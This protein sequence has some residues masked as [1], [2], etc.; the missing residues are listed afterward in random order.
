MKRGFMFLHL[1][2]YVKELKILTFA[3]INTFIEDEKYKK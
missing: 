2:S 3:R 1:L